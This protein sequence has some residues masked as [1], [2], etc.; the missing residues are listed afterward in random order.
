M[1]PQNLRFG[2]GATDTV[3]HP[4]IAVEMALAIILILC[5]PRKTIIA[6]FLWMIFT[7]P[8]GQVL[9]AGGVHFTVIRIIILA[10]LA[11]WV[12]S[13]RSQSAGRL[14]DGLNSIDRVFILWAVSELVISSIQL[15][16]T[17][18]LIQSCGDFLDLLG[19]YMVVRFMIQDRD[20]VLRAIKVFAVI[21]SF[22]ACCMMGE[23]LT[24]KNVFGMLGGAPLTPQVRAGRSV[25]RERSR[26]TSKREYL[27]PTSSRC[28]SCCGRSGSPGLLRSWELSEG[29]LWW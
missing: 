16:Q 27:A 22:M 20:D 26:H 17:Q 29:L 23:K 1:E 8:I 2:G 28:S 18:A 11:R 3:L 14:E 7:V 6:P 12:V 24:G 4:L 10:G 13:G 21:A 5:L 9:V 19:G 15:M 25:P